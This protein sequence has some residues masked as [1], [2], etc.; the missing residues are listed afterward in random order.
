MTDPTKTAIVMILDRSG[1]MARIA[2]ATRE[3][4][5]AFVA[6][7][8]GQPGEC[9]LTL[10]QFDD[11][12]EPV[13]ADRPIGQV[14]PLTL[15]PRG[16]TALLDA[17][18]RTITETGERLAGLPED[19]R[20]GTVIVG[21]VTDGHENSSREWT[22]PAVKALIEQQ[23]G[24]YGWTFM[25]LGANQDAVEVGASMGISADRSLT[26]AGHNVGQA[27]GAYSASVLRMRGAAAEGLDAEQAREAASFSAKERAA[28]VR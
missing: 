5:D 8:A 24:V 9:T 20:P 19:A 11:R 4:F 7:Q 16:S 3:G 12:I 22:H 25:Y 13:Y 2:D 17:V 21:I 18:G 27:A 6:E 26:Y 10:V 14:P 15:V 28:A 23:E 1:S